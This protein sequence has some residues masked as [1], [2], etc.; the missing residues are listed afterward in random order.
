MPAARISRFSCRVARAVSCHD[1]HLPPLGRKFG[2]AWGGPAPTGR[3][4]SRRGREITGICSAA[5]YGSSGSNRIFP[6]RRRLTAHEFV[7]VRGARGR[8]ELR[9]LFIFLSHATVV[10]VNSLA[11]RPEPG[12]HFMT[13]DT[14]RP[15]ACEP[16]RRGP[17]RRPEHRH[18]PPETKRT[19]E[20]LS[21]QSVGLREGDP[22]RRRPALMRSGLGR[23]QRVQALP[24][25]GRSRRAGGRS[26]AG[27]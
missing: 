11:S 9:S 10:G 17:V 22:H 15:G 23:K 25:A 8:G 24:A 16:R 1:V 5:R 2:L 14:Q 3:G 6:G 20:K 19:R 27:R 13:T 7:D 4:N 12:P 26:D 21:D 18:Q